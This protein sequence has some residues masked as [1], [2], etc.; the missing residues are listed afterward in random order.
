MTAGCFSGQL[1]YIEIQI[2]QSSTH[3]AAMAAI[4]TESQKLQEAMKGS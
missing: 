1:L 4:N 2:F 3:R